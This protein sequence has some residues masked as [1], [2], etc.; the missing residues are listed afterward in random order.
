MKG[1][2]EQIYK[3]SKGY[4][5]IVF[6]DRDGTIIRE[7]GYL[8]NED[9]I[10]ILPK[11]IDGIRILNQNNIAVIVVTNQPVVAR[12]L[13]NIKDLKR[14]NN[15]IV[16]KLEKEGV[17]ISAIYSCPHHP[18]VSHSDTPRF[19]MKFRI[20]C[21]CRKP[22][23]AMYKKA[24]SVFGSKK[25][26]GVIGDNTRD[27]AAGKKLSAPTVI[28]RTGDKGEDEIYD[29]SP[30]FISDDFLDAVQILLQ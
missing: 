9:D 12:G 2:I 23:I 17:Y 20:V 14:I 1:F 15:E 13:I 22:G 25:I 3:D 21:E 4:K 10:E 29:V 28:V 19:A 5:G 11:V 18:E 24:I 30:D 16:S 8:Q 7:V 27:T 6:L 26:L